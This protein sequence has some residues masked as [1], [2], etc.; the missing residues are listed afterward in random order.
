M[1][2]SLTPALCNQP[3]VLLS[4]SLAM[5]LNFANFIQAA[6]VPFQVN[7]K[8]KASWFPFLVFVVGL[9]LF[10]LETIFE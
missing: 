5:M 2:S 3:H 7:N 1:K 6:T 9:K 10:C 8:G 4:S